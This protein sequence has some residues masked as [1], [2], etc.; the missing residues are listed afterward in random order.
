MYLYHPTMS[1]RVSGQAISPLD[2]I[3]S[4]NRIVVVLTN[5]PVVYVVYAS[6]KAFSKI[7]QVSHLLLLHV[8]YSTIL[9]QGAPNMSLVRIYN[10]TIEPVMGGELPVIDFRKWVG[11]PVD[12]STQ[13]G[14][15]ES[16]EKC[17]GRQS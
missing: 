1:N 12:E 6:T 16:M 5:G 17:C 7:R 4:H 15:D 2:S 13:V 10:V 11:S 3:R 9:H 14:G 8:I